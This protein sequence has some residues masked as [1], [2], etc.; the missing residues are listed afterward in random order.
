[1]FVHKIF[2]F[3]NYIKLKYR[4]SKLNNNSCRKTTQ[5]TLEV[6][7]RAAFT[8]REKCTYNNNIILFGQSVILVLMD[9]AFLSNLF[10][11]IYN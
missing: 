10:I 7:T 11:H 1:M 2:L 4:V 9:S 5:R 3:S 6:L 8:Q